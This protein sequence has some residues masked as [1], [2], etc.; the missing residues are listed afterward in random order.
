ML[1][2]LWAKIKK[3]CGDSMT[4]AWGY[5]QIAMSGVLN[6]IDLIGATV[7]DG[8]FKET[9]NTAVND[10]KLVAKILLVTGVITIFARMRSLYAQ[11]KS[12]PGDD[13]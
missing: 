2:S 11:L 6:M 3:V 8:A 9:I 12:P 13:K 5:I 7:N 1:K 10:T 4:I